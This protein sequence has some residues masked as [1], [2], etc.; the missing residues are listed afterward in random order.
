M[1]CHLGLLGRG[2]LII[3]T[4]NRAIGKNRGD[5]RCADLNRFLHDQIH[6]FSLGNCLAECDATAE[7]WRLRVVQFAKMDLRCIARNDLSGDLASLPLKRT[8]LSARS[9][10]RTLRQ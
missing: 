9:R 3:Q 1:L 4:D 2:A 8:T 5:F 6:V 10:R 7:R